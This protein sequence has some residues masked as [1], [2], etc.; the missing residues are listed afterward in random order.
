MLPARTAAYWRYGPLSPS[1]LR[2]SSMS[3]TMIFVRENL[4]MK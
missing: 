4:T 1:K 2:A 3:N